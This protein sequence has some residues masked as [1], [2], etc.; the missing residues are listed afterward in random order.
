MKKIGLTAFCFTSLLHFTIAQQSITL[1]DIWKKNTF[2]A[3]FSPAYQSTK[4][5]EHYLDYADKGIVDV[6]AYVFCEYK[7]GKQ[8]SVLFKTNELIPEGKNEPV[9]MERMQI[10][11]EEDK[12][13][14]ETATEHIYR[15]STKVENY[16]F[17]LKT[18]KM[19]SLS[20]NGKQRLAQF[21]PDG[22][23]AAFVR[24]N[25]IFVTDLET[26]KES[27]VTTDGVWNKIINGGTDWV[28]EE[29]FALPNGLYWS[30]DS[31]RIAFLRF[32][33]SRVKE[34]QMTL[35]NTGL[36]PEPYSYKYPK[37]GEDNSIVT[38]HIYDLSTKQIIPVNT[39]TETNQ[40][41]PRVQ[42]TN[43]GNMLSFYRMNRLQNKLELLFA[44]ASDGTS[45][46]IYTETD[47]KYIEINDDLTF[48]PGG[49][50]FICS[51]D[52]SG[53]HHLYLMGMDGKQ[54]S[55]ITMG[56]WEVIKY[57]GYDEKNKI[58]YYQSNEGNAV[59]TSVYSIRTDGKGKKKLST[60]AGANDAVFSNGMK[61]YVN[62]YS[63][64]NRPY[65]V[66]LHDAV[67]NQI[68]ILKD[69]QALIDKVNE[70]GF[71]KKTFMTIETPD[72]IKLNAWVI[73]PSKMDDGKKY[74]VLQI[75]YGGPGKNTV[76]DQWESS[77]FQWQQMLVQ[78][79]YIVASVD[80]RGTERRGK[81][82]KQATY[83]RMGELESADQIEMAKYMGALSYV[84]KNRIGIFGWSYG[85]Y[86]S[87]LC[88]AVGA[89]YFKLAISVAP[90]GSWRFYDSIYTERYMGLPQ[91]N[92]K[93][94]DAFSPIYNMDK[95]RG[96][97][98][99]VHGTADDNVHFQ[100]SVEI[101]NALIK[102]DKQFDFY[103]YPDKN[104][105]IRGGNSRLHLYTKMTEF[106]KGNL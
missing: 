1:D 59:Q 2:R 90:V 75:V 64:A 83:G 23:K 14:I 44:N 31:K 13:L 80:N 91:D 61:Y 22:K 93:G 33:E 45:N 18:R 99:L 3:E 39:G 104:H 55:Q 21:S 72:G 65:L 66:T 9:K 43:D 89:D 95:I 38:L 79:G 42:W 67:G 52:K 26:R 25:N 88:L 50:S 78:Q 102:A 19:Y 5:G 6:A 68:K 7:T 100:N 28:Y 16:V 94:Y 77:D 51:S 41:I 24:D 32:D 62:T 37:A 46:V 8:T 81:E 98:L 87:S 73:K 53:Y 48:L 35:Y 20:V 84:D 106:L 49:K 76:L 69:N 70:Y 58:V 15:H 60:G 40:Y 101:V 92:A 97:L 57:Y 85:G 29:E 17:D 86:M 10:S 4:D 47:T 63:N 82:F 71:E 12:L 34:F 30:P 54:I 27:Q 36:Y 74:P 56:E 105:G 96:K 103:M 11:P